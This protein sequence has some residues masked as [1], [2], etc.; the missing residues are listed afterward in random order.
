MA[1]IALLALAGITLL[2][3]GSIIFFTVHVRKK[4]K[5]IRELKIE[6]KMRK[7]TIANIWETDRR[8]NKQIENLQKD[9]KDMYIKTSA[10]RINRKGDEKMDADKRKEEL[11]KTIIQACKWIQKKLQISD[12]S[13]RDENVPEMMSALAELVIVRNERGEESCII[14]E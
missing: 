11:D 1:N 4:E 2:N 3:S 8:Q 12:K 14:V 9:L 13:I 6:Q 10:V 7:S 5:E